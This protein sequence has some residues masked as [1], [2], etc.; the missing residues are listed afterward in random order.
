MLTVWHAPAKNDAHGKRRAIQILLQQGATHPPWAQG[1]PAVGVCPSRLPN[2]LPPPCN[3]PIVGRGYGPRPTRDATLLRNR[4]PPPLPRPSPLLSP[5]RSPGGGSTRLPR[6]GVA[7]PTPPPNPSSASI[8][9]VLIPRRP[10]SPPPPLRAL[11][12]PRATRRRPAAAGSLSSTADGVRSSL[13]PPPP[14]PR[15]N[16]QVSSRRCNPTRPLR[17]Q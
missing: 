11:L 14:H 17:C 2:P 16:P 15:S 3:S 6:A 7:P 13:P 8:A 4:R 10:H 9:A 12:P 1:G 5:R